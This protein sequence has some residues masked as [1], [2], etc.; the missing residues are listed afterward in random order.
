MILAEPGVV[1]LGGGGC[2]CD[3]VTVDTSNLLRNLLVF[4]VRTR[5]T[6]YKGMQA[7]RL[8]VVCL[9]GMPTGLLRL[10]V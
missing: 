4:V 2:V 6:V 9:A 5:R 1:N 10:C 8:L 3:D 7:W